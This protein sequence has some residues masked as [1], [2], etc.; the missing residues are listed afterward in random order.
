MRVAANVRKPLRRAVL[1]CVPLFPVLVAVSLGAAPTYFKVGS[2]NGG[3][4]YTFESHPTRFT[5]PSE[6]S[7]VRFSHLHW[8][9]WGARVSVASG[10]ASTHDSQSGKTVTASVRLTAE[11][12]RQGLYGPAYTTVIASRIPLY[13]PNPVALPVS[14]VG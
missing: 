9:H 12:L 13:G 1:L 8:S 10:L 7:S 5:V 6:D 11:R 2:F 3:D 14:R 4:T